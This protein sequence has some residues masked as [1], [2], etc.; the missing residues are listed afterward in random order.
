MFLF[1]AFVNQK[2]SDFYEIINLRKYIK[3]NRV[4]HKIDS[5][6]IKEHLIILDRKKS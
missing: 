5:F 2:V 6:F 4:S 3:T 1:L